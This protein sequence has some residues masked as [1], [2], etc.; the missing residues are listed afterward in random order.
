[1]KKSAFIFSEKREEDGVASSAA[2]GPLIV[3]S[4][5]F[6]IPFLS[7]MIRRAWKSRCGW[8]RHC[9]LRSLSERVMATSR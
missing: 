7:E 6:Q 3:P 4:G 9:C 5:P 8:V 2:V 1:M